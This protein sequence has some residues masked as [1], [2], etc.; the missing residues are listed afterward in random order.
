MTVLR[1]ACTLLLFLPVACSGTPAPPRPPSAE[2]EEIDGPRDSDPKD[3]K[4][5]VERG[6]DYVD[7]G[8]YDKAVADYKEAMRLAPEEAEA[9]NSLAWLLATCTEDRVRDGKKAVELAT[10]ACELSKWE[11]AEIVGTLAAA[12]AECGHFDEAVKWQKKALKL[13]FDT[14]EDTKAARAQLKL[15]EAGKPFREK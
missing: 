5:Y 14:D 3:A 2:E 1:V 13:G 10:K 11:D 6:D 4:G 12:H 7:Q 8:E 9:Y 15:Y